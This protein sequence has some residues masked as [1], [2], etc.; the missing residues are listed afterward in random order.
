MKNEPAL[1]RTMD[2][3]SWEKAYNLWFQNKGLAPGR[4]PYP[5]HKWNTDPDS[6]ERPEEY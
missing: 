1:E 4:H 3:R 5:E 2:A 6:F